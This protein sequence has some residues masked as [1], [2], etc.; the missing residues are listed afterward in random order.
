[1]VEE[2]REEGGRGHEHD[3]EKRQTYSQPRTGTL[4]G[5]QS[6]CRPIVS[7]GQAHRMATNQK[8]YSYP[9]GLTLG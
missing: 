6:K 1:M 4:H 8:Q 5:N 7:P 3:G 2:G 9:S